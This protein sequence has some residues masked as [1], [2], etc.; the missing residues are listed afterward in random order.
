MAEESERVGGIS[1][2]ITG[3]DKQL[4]AALDA[5]EARIKAWVQ[6]VNANYQPKVGVAAPSGGRGG[7]ASPDMSG[8]ERQ[9]AALTQALN[10]GG[11]GAA[12]RA[13]ADAGQVTINGVKVGNINSLPTSLQ[14]A[15]GPVEVQADTT[16]ALESIGELRV[17]TSKPIAVNLDTGEFMAAIKEM[18]AAAVTLKET[19]A[20]VQPPTT[21]RSGGGG[22]STRA[23]KPASD[24]AQGTAAD[25]GMEDEEEAA[26]GN[27]GGRVAILRQPRTSEYEGGP[28]G[29]QGG[30]IRIRRNIRGT[31]IETQRNYRVV[32]SPQ[33]RAAEQEARERVKQDQQASI[34]AQA[35]QA[36]LEQE[37]LFAN[38]A[39][40]E[41][42]G[43]ENL[44]STFA[45][46]RQ[47]G[48]QPSDTTQGRNMRGGDRAD[49]ERIAQ[50]QQAQAQRRTNAAYSAEPVGRGGLGGRRQSDADIE[51]AAQERLAIREATAVSAGRTARTGASS[52]LGNFLFGGGRQ[53]G[54]A[55]SALSIAIAKTRREQRDLNEAVRFYRSVN[56]DAKASDEDR[57]GALAGVREQSERVAKAIDAE[58]AARKKVESFSGVAAG[59]RNLLAITA[60][61]SLFGIGLKAV[62]VAI[63]AAEK[64][65]TPY[66]DRMTDYAQKTA[67]LTSALADQTRAQ[68]GN[69]QGVVALKLAQTGYAS[70]VAS[71]VQPVIQ[72]RAQVEAGNKALVEQIE[73]FRMAE[74][75]RKQNPNAGISGGGTGGVQGT[76]LFGI[77]STGEQAGN[78]LQSLTSTS[79]PIKDSASGAYKASDGT[80]RVAGVPFALPGSMVPGSENVDAMA[81]ATKARGISFLNEQ[82]K[83][84]GG[85]AGTFQQGGSAPQ[86]AALKAAF[87]GVSPEMQKAVE[88][89][90]LFS[91]SITDTTTALAALRALNI[92]GT[93]TGPAEQLAAQQMAQRNQA[94]SVSAI[95]ARQEYGRAAFFGSLQR[96]GEAQIGTMLPAQAAL[97]NLANPPTPVGTGINAANA[98]EAKKVRDYTA[99]TQDLQD[100]LNAYYAKGRSILENTYKPAIMQSFGQAGVQAFTNIM[101]QITTVGQ[102][103]A[104]ISAG[105]SNEQAEYQT[106]QYNYQ[107]YI[108]RR[109]L[110][111]IRQLTGQI[112]KTEGDN[113]GLYER[114]NL[115]LGRQAQQ[116][117][118]V[119]SQR[120]INLQRALA[121]FVVPG[122]TPAEQ[123]ARVQEAKVEADFAQ[124]QL[125]IQKQMFGNQ[126]KIVDIGNLRQAS[127]L[128]KQIGLLEQ[129]RKVTLDTQLAQEKLTRLSEMQQALTAEASVYITTVN[130]QIAKAEADMTEIEA[131]TGT[132]ISKIMAQGIKAAYAVGN[133]FFLGISGGFLGSG[134]GTPGSSGGSQVRKANA[135]GALYN[136]QG[137]TSLGPYGIAGEAG[138]ET[139]A[140]LRNPK[141]FML[142]TGGGGGG[143]S[144]NFYGDINVRSEAD[145]EAIARRVTQAQGR[146][147][148]LSGLRGPN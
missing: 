22:R 110:T 108:A 7:G 18:T 6:K 135:S 26:Q 52:Y 73:T 34:E 35:A 24:V 140:I 21:R 38:S 60:A 94:N 130:Q 89:L 17:S 28:F 49:A 107:L 82:I 10:R 56:R 119:L 48:G 134:D 90:G 125:D 142:S 93:L 9:M 124:K 15:I 27:R 99:E 85:A 32:I 36:R 133:A 109:S 144:V 92:A 132:R 29:N 40:N 116:L 78:F 113:L 11:A 55:E 64:A 147:A 45:R 66:F 58:G 123:N 63:A 83:M 43:Q 111:D 70:S 87:E 72:Q 30:R 41:A 79:L 95:Q 16:A 84:G 74:R 96:Q 81:A 137:T 102:S 122:L 71:S 54:E 101:G 120:Q 53:R 115:L 1:V 14:K 138:R 62:D 104:K 5:A 105:I 131:A 86:V 129:G 67:D 61:G 136:T 75:L 25:V 2:D 91:T 127:D 3:S 121:G 143:G 23:R 42:A 114:A 65:A 117:Q 31:G 12:R 97:A 112:G 8:L 44:G 148:S 68:Q 139:V 77:P 126:V 106:A 39:A 57:A 50:I 4:E 33:Q 69:A 59:A 19:L 145:I 46:Q 128:V 100:T 80:Y 47:P 146:R 51:R 118:F 20:T 13:Q 37:M 141:P 76:S 103:M 98:A 88:E